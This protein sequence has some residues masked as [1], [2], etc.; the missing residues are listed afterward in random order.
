MRKRW[1]L[2]AAAA[3]LL[4]AGLVARRVVQRRLE[5]GML[6]VRGQGSK[7]PGTYGAPFTP[8]EIASGGR[9]L[10]AF[11]VAPPDPQAPRALAIFH[12][13]MESISSWS[14]VQA[15]LWQRGVGSM[16]FDYSGF[17]RSTGEPTVENLHQDG[18]AAWAAFRARLPPG[19][20]ACAYGLSLGSGVLLETAPELQPAPDCLIVYGAF[21][22]GLAAAAHLRNLPAPLIG[23][24]PD[25]FESEKNARRAPAPLLVQ[26]GDADELFPV[27]MAEGIARAAPQGRLLVM[28]GYKHA[29]PLVEPDDAAWDPVIAHVRG[30]AF[31]AR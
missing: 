22:S 10:Q 28:P 29:Q 21:T 15:F 19:T 24:L 5:R 16:V 12:G 4:V 20:R 7:T 14:A 11:Y 2:L 6:V 8:V 27:S 9:T 23:L 25:V 17:G 31:P 30:E 3:V 1:L 26:H 18:K 13:R